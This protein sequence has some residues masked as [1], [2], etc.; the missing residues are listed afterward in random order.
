MFAEMCDLA[1]RQTQVKV[2]TSTPAGMAEVPMMIMQHFSHYM[3]YYYI[4]SCYYIMSGINK[5]LNVISYYIITTCAKPLL[6]YATMVL[7]NDELIITL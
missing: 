7:L 6:H 5:A 1:D 4:M 3:S 2:F